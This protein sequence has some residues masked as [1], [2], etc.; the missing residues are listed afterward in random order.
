MRNLNRL[1]ID[2]SWGLALCDWKLRFLCAT[3][4]TRLRF[5]CA[6]FYSRLRFLSASL[7]TPLGC[8]VSRGLGPIGIRFVRYL[9]A[10]LPGIAGSIGSTRRL[11]KAGREQRLQTI[12]TFFRTLCPDSRQKRGGFGLCEPESGPCRCSRAAANHRADV[13]KVVFA[14]DSAMA[15]FSVATEIARNTII[16]SKTFTITK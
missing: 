7:S 4:Y 9:R 3:F 10:I 15:S 8:M 16:T 1:S 6:S 13:G 11:G 12:R 2:F 5:L 14:T